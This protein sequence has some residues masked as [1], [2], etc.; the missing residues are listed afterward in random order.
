MSDLDAIFFCYKQP[1]ATY[2]TLQS[3]KQYYPD[4]VVYLISDNGYDYSK[5]A[6]YF[7]CKYLHFN[8]NIYPGYAKDYKN[9]S[10]KE[11]IE[12]LINF[13]NI[14]V[15]GFLEL[16]KKFV[17]LL[18]D[19][20]RILGN[21][22]T[23]N[24][25]GSLNGPLINKIPGYVFDKFN[26]V[27]NSK[28][29]YYNGGGG[30]IYNRKDFLECINNK[31]ILNKLIEQYLSYNLNSNILCGDQF[32]SILMIL[33]NKKIELNP[34]HIETSSFNINNSNIK[35]QHQFKYYYNYDYKSKAS[36][37]DINNMIKFGF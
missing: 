21:I 12:N 14:I 30:A 4:G 26:N 16:N 7:G 23:N 33:N 9:L 5:M 28:P 32:Y 18:E 25:K 31:I 22:N 11:R 10:E 34:Y 13:T 1:F 17:I 6:E 3:F 20:V 2:K 15:K 29:E 35:V 36:K 8:E 24:L 27:T 37:E 19:D